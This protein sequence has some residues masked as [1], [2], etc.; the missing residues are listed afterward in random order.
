MC[1]ISIINNRVFL[2]NSIRT[3]VKENQVNFMCI[4]NVE[5]HYVGFK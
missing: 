4:G 2:I 1:A 5:I 3:P